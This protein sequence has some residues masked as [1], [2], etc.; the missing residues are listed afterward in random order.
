MKLQRARQYRP[1]VIHDSSRVRHRSRF[2]DKAGIL[3]SYLPPGL[4][5]DVESTM[6][7]SC[8]YGIHILSEIN[9]YVP[10]ELRPS[11]EPSFECVRGAIHVRGILDYRIGIERIRSLLPEVGLVHSRD[12]I[13]DQPM[14]EG[15]GMIAVVK[16]AYS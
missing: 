16:P 4:R 7:D 8:A 12:M 15:A 13:A 2:H 1:T 5:A 11:T 3:I 14:V 10:S 9:L 6:W